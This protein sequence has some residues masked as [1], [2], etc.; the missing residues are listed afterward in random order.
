M[1][2]TNYGL[3]HFKRALLF[4]EN[5]K[6]KKINI[7]EIGSYAGSSAAAFVKYFPK[8][9]VFCFDINISNFEY[10]SKNIHVFGIDIN[11]KKKVKK[12]FFI[13]NILPF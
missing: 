11:N 5:F 12:N 1:S 2:G 3:G 4:K 6:N 9:N 10:K 13:S 8:S 7:L